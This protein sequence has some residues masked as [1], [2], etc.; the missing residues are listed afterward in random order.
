MPG[1]S[2]QTAG[3]ARRQGYGLFWTSN[4]NVDSVMLCVL[5]PLFENLHPVLACLRLSEVNFM[6]THAW[7]LFPNNIPALCFSNTYTPNGS[8]CVLASSSRKRTQHCSWI[9]PLVFPNNQPERSMSGSLSR[10]AG[11]DGFL[12]LRRAVEWLDVASCLLFSKPA[13]AQLH[14]LCLWLSQNRCTRYAMPDFFAQI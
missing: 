8:L 6:G 5:Y 12:V 11:Y 1:S 13:S 14:E 9:L 3:T 4:R 2:S 10:I 7:F